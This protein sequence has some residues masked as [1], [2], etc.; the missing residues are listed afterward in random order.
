M[1][2]THR[3]PPTLLQA[4]KRKGVEF[5]VAP[6]EADAQLAYLA[7][8]NSVDVVITEDSDLLAYGCPR[9]SPCAQAAT[10]KPGGGLSVLLEALLAAAPELPPACAQAGV[11]QDGP[12]RR[13][14]GD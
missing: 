7:I 2:P 9:V 11:L 6:Y 5:I 4:L 8:N 3:L 12:V 1:A 14:G 13:G 10:L